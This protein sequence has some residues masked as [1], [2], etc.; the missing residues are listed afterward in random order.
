MTQ[1]IVINA[2]KFKED[3]ERVHIIAEL[4]DIMDDFSR[5]HASLVRNCTRNQF[6]E[7]ELEIFHRIQGDTRC[8]R[9]V[10]LY[11][12]NGR[13]I[14][15]DTKHYDSIIHT[16]L[17][18]GLEDDSITGDIVLYKTGQRQGWPYRTAD[19]HYSGS[20]HFITGNVNIPEIY[21]SNR[22]LRL[23]DTHNELYQSYCEEV[24]PDYHSSSLKRAMSYRLYV[25]MHMTYDEWV[26]T[27]NGSFS[28]DGRQIMRAGHLIWTDGEVTRD[29]QIGGM[30]HPRF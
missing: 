14:K 9:W 30:P 1:T 29:W 24:F 23:D 4:G 6:T 13:T 28:E 15:F 26:N 17:L 5:P 10:A 25:L 16:R 21:S 7:Q 19:E 20:H 11:K 22:D 2:E 12:K 27:F 8:R 3:R 18:K